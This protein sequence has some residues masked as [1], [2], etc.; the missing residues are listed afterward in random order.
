VIES[1]QMDSISLSSL[2]AYLLPV[3][4]VQCLVS[5]AIWYELRQ[6]RAGR[7]SMSYWDAVFAV[8]RDTVAPE[9]GPVLRDVI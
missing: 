3:A 4:L 1:G 2:A 9:A 8:R 5:A 7:A 6:L